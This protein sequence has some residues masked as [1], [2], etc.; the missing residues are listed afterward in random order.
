VTVQHSL[1]FLVLILHSAWQISTR[2]LPFDLEKVQEDVKVGNQAKMTKALWKAYQIA[3]K[4]H[5]LAHFKKV[6]QEHKTAMASAAKQKRE[7]KAQ[8]GNEKFRTSVK[9]KRAE[10][11]DAENEKVS[12]ILVKC[13]TTTNPLQACKYS[14]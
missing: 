9:R 4:G 6:L 11:V 10:E 2:L 14:Q 13:C 3:A 8:K 7:Q 12:S 1:H 5:D